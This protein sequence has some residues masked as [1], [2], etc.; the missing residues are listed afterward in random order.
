MCQPQEGIH[1]ANG[2]DIAYR[3]ALKSAISKCKIAG[4]STCTFLTEIN[5]GYQNRPGDRLGVCQVEVYVTGDE[6]QV[7]SGLKDIML[8]AKKDFS[9]DAR[10]GSA[11]FQNN[12]LKVSKTLELNSCTFTWN[13]PN[14]PTG[15][16]TI[17]KGTWFPVFK[18]ESRSNR[19]RKLVYLKNENGSD[20]SFYFS[21]WGFSDEDIVKD[22]QTIAGDF[23]E[24]IFV[25][26]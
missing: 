9:Y 16:V 26:R 22:F 20:S 18:D 4:N 19:D 11:L 2:Y 12:V 8:E 24:I 6:V 17:E 15:V 7:P 25:T 13:F 10:Q 5:Y 14:R 1:V 23:F 3:C 21:C